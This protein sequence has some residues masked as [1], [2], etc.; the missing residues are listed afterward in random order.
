MPWPSWTAA[1][2]FES[3]L[4][5]AWFSNNWIHISPLSTT[6]LALIG[7]LGLVVLRYAHDNMRGE[8]SARRFM[9]A[10]VLTLTAVVVT[11]ASNNLILFAMGWIGVS[12]SLHQL[13]L[14]YPDRSRAV[15]AAH[16]KFLFARLAEA[17]LIAAFLLLWLQH[18]TLNIQSI[19]LHYQT[20]DTLTL[21]DQSI[22]VLLA[23][24]ALIK[25]AQMPL[26]GWLIQ[27]VESPT[28]VSALLHAGIV[29]LGG[30]LLLLFAPLI[31]LADAARW[32]LLIVAGLSCVLA[33]LVMMTR[34]SI[35]VRLAWSTV[36]QMGLMLVECALGLYHL[37]LLHLVAHSFYKAHAFLAS[38]TAVASYL[39]GQ[40]AGYRLPRLQ[41]WLMALAITVAAALA[42]SPWLSPVSLISPWIL[43]GIACATVLAWHFSY[44][45]A[46]CTARGLL[47]AA[48]APLLYIA[49]TTIAAH[50]AYPDGESPY[51]LASMSADLWI[52]ALFIT[53]FGLFLFL[54]YASRQP[55]ARRLFVIMNAGF[56]LDEW[57]SR[58][59]L[60]LYPL[61]HKPGQRKHLQ[62]RAA[63]T[64]ETPLGGSV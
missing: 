59:T 61:R 9:L 28:P 20:V 35:K 23:L 14:F 56:Y 55:V 24:V 18:Q 60:W 25:C 13:L 43:I 6:I 15:L 4:T 45:R 47:L 11:V 44:G 7:L 62:P 10:M 21:P 50:I 17:L 16:K 63:T 51:R 3:A 19:I 30:F 36:A 38:G 42:V 26:H 32:L 49:L 41:H 31:S 29:N 48:A 54:Y 2:G 37:A 57:A 39:S 52:S 40:A 22:A 58:V 12:L 1:S 53:Q 34:I 8:A 64:I 46:G 5:D 33:A 27:V